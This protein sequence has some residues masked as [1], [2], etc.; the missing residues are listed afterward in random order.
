MDKFTGLCT[1]SSSSQERDKK[2][3]CTLDRKNYILSLKAGQQTLILF[4][5]QA[6]VWVLAIYVLPYTQ[7]LPS[8]K[9][10]WRKH[11]CRYI[12]IGKY[13]FLTLSVR[14]SST[15]QAR[16]CCVNTN[17]CILSLAKYVSLYINKHFQNSHL[18][19]P[20]QFCGSKFYP[21]IANK[22]IVSITLSSKIIQVLLWSHSADHLN[23]VGEEQ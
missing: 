15:K 5:S 4:F 18:H 7:I 14:T 13:F 9:Q 3:F 23:K 8:L 12:F 21:C 19:Q 1:P 16:K 2:S 22:I 17:I 6:Y 20:E 10:Q 11:C